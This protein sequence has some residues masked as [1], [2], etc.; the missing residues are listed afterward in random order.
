MSVSLAFILINGWSRFGKE[1]LFFKSKFRVY[2]TSIFIGFFQFIFF[3]QGRRVNPN[4][5]QS[6]KK[7]ILSPFF[8]GAEDGRLRTSKGHD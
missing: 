6:K 2:F 3:S 5:S 1:N 4:N 7:N 8:R